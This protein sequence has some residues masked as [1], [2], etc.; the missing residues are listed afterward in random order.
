MF[1]TR[2]RA[3]ALVTSRRVIDCMHA[4]YPLDHFANETA[5]FVALHRNHEDTFA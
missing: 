3:S 5:E 2:F 1:V 4:A